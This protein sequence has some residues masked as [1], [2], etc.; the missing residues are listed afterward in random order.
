MSDN[1]AATPRSLGKMLLGLLVVAVYLFPVYW[2]IATSLKTNGDVFTI[3]PEVF[4]SPL[5][6]GSY[7]EAVL[8]SPPVIRSLLNSMVI[9]TGTLLLTLAL[10]APAAYGLARL[11][12]RFTVA[13]SLLLLLAQMLPT[14]NLALPLFV[15]F[16]GVGLVDTYLGLVLANTALAMPF[17]IIILRP[18]FLTIPGE[19]MDAARVDG[20]GRFGSFVRI[21]LPLARPG[22]ITVGALAFVTAWGEFVFGLTLATSEQMQPVTV[23]LNRFIGQYG[24]R[25]ADLMAVATV[26][27]LP[28]TL[29]FAGLQRFI[30]SGITTGATKE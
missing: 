25:W 24:T 30:V 6:F 28:I 12:L 1:Q 7:V 20:C 21:A 9:A 16:S 2:M 4:P 23:A 10:G 22:L 29:I 13:I 14:I 26:A 18:F 17:A 3:P 15:I 11:R 8:N 5:V 27:A 19:L